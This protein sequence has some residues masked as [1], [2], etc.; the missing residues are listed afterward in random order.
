[1]YW[2]SSRVGLPSISMERLEQLRAEAAVEPLIDGVAGSIVFPTIVRNVNTGQSEPLGFIFAVD[3]EYSQTFG[4]TSVEGVPL[5]TTDLEPGIGNIFLQAANVFAIVPELASQFQQ[6]QDDTGLSL[7]EGVGVATVVAG[8]GALLTG[9]DPAMLP[10]LSV[11]TD[12]LDSLGV[13]TE[14]FRAVGRNEISLP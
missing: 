14:P 6:F 9:V 8:V 1:M 13:D 7:D 10:D 11:S 3:D 5:S 4:L 12:T 2:R